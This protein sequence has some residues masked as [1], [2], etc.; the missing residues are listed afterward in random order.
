MMIQMAWRNLWRQPRRTILTTLAIA[1]T[2][3]FLIFMP[4]LQNGSYNVMIENT[5]RLFYGYGEIQQPGYHDNP[6][7][8]NSIPDYQKIIQQLERIHGLTGIGA[9]AIG[10]AIL[11]SN[12]RNFGAQI[13]GVQPASERLISTIPRNISQGHYLSDNNSGEILLGETLARNLRVKPGDSI[14]LLGMA[15]D[16]SLAADSLKVAGTFNMG[17]GEMNRLLA[18]IPL[19]RF[20]DTYAMQN[21]VHTLVLAAHNIKDFQP[22]MPAIQK[23]AAQH[24]LQ[25]LDWKQL[26]PGLLQG[27]L[28]DMSS[29]AL[30]YL[31]MVIVVTFSL[32]NS[33]L[34]SVLERTRE[35]GVLL[36]LGMR[37]ALIARMLW[38]EIILLILLGL[39]LGILLGYGI[40]EYYAYTGIHFEGSEQL[41]KKFGLPAAMY[42]AVN[43]YT[44]L[45]GPLFIALC[46]LL[47]GIFPVMRIYRMQA[48]PAMRSI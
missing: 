33:L 16:G 44:L 36:A 4:S 12:E 15:R 19:S 10:S 45:G 46:I 43:L 38:L 11:S 40:T 29:A 1:F 41:F 22:L 20:Q 35:F 47:S 14:T 25:A 26:Q 23:I 9:R 28:L 31:A 6:E 39:S 5:M 42:P 7:I 17:I 24:H 34:M 3:V 13:V 2:C 32:L 37:P 8:R 27:I 30:I 18:Q 21:Q 48:V